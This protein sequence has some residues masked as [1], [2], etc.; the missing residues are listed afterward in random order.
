VGS[1]HLEPHQGEEQHQEKF[2]NIKR[3]LALRTY[4]EKIKNT[5]KKRGA[6]LGEDQ[7]NTWN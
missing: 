5:K 3:G 1:I 2:K 4:M 6:A 7:Q